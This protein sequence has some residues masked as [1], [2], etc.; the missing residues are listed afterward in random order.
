MAELGPGNGDPVPVRRALEDLG[1]VLRRGDS[2]Q[3][4][5]LARLPADGAMD[6]VIPGQLVLVVTGPEGGRGQ[7]ISLVVLEQL[8]SQP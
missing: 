3:Q 2:H 7:T 1:A 6:V 8:E 4:V 5:R